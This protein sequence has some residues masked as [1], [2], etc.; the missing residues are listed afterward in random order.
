MPLS[1]LIPMVVFGIAGIVVILHLLGLTAP[2]SLPDAAAARRA[3]L[4]EFPDLAPT[5]ISLARDRRAA[6]IETDDGPGVVWTV[7]ADTT[8]RRLTRADVSHLDNRLDLRLGDFTAPRV[9]LEL[10]PDTI[11]RL[12]GRTDI[13]P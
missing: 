7:G 6:L 8:A 10:E 3:W 9:Q 4:R 5:R 11:A 12:H 13:T 1:V 2:A